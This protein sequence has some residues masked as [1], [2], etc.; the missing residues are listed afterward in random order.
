MTEPHLNS[1]QLQQIERRAQEAIQ[2]AV[3]NMQLRKW[4]I[5]QAFTLCHSTTVLE[6]Y[7]PTMGTAATVDP[8]TLAKAVYAF[9]SQPTAVKVEIGG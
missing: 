6:Q 2:A 4:S 9:V 1:A 8:M 3:D 5:E 7:T